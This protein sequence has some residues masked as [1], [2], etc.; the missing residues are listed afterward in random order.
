MATDPLTRLTMEMVAHTLG[1]DQ[2]QQLRIEFQVRDHV[3]RI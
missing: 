1:A 2:I 3:V